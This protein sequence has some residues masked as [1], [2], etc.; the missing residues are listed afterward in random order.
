METTQTTQSVKTPVNA[1]KEFISDVQTCKCEKVQRKEKNPFVLC[2]LR[3]P[4]M[5]MGIKNR[6]NR[7]YTEQLIRERILENPDVQEKMKNKQLLGEGDHPADD[8]SYVSY[9]EVALSVTKLWIP[10]EDPQHL[11]GEFDVLPT[12]KGKDLAAIVDYA[13]VIGI[14]ARAFGTHYINAEGAEVLE[15]SSYDFI[16]FDAVPDP[17]FS[18]AR[19]SVLKERLNGNKNIYAEKNIKETNM[20]L[21]NYRSYKVSSDEMK[22]EAVS[23]PQQQNA[24]LGIKYTPMLPASV[25][26]ANL[27]LRER[28][29][30]MMKEKEVMKVEKKALLEQLASLKIG[31]DNANKELVQKKQ[32]ERKSKQNSDIELTKANKLNALYKERLEA[33]KESL[34]VSQENYE[35][36]KKD[37]TVALRAK[38]SL[39]A[40]NKDLR[41]E[42]EHV[43]VSNKYLLK[44]LEYYKKQCSNLSEDIEA[45]SNL[46]ASLKDSVSKNE[47]E[48]KSLMDKCVLLEKKARKL[49]LENEALSKDKNALEDEILEH[50]EEKESYVNKIQELQ[51]LH[52]NAK[53]EAK[54]LSKTLAKKES[55]NSW[56][57]QS[58]N[59]MQR[60]AD[61]EVRKENCSES[62]VTTETNCEEQSL[63]EENNPVMKWNSVFKK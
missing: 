31:L 38:K 17:G 28:L 13:G 36:L 3:G 34:R 43:D 39:F 50:C 46:S 57:E 40:E 44:K 61:T 47:Y 22:K 23:K 55:S 52:K 54:S 59:R 4:C 10:K 15:T 35:A 20:V 21:E 49:S 48:K 51:R 7:I 26:N 27:A 63:V 6:N 25:I 42:V 56:Q 11:W 53:N 30:K 62:K 19:L 32:F 5:E 2:T 12:S 45:L 16:T 14:S 33:A 41:Q 18:I 8:R 29:D 9:P 60:Y 58:N 24:G 1:H 37:L